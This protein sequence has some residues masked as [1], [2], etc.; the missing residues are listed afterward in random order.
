MGAILDLIGSYIFKAAMIGIIFATSYSL[1]E[2]MTKKAQM[3]NLEKSLNVQ[4]SVAEWDLRNIGYG[5]S[6]ANKFKSVTSTDLW[7]YGDIDN[8]G[9]MDSVRYQITTPYITIRDSLVRRYTITRRV[10]NGTP[11]N[12]MVKLRHLDVVYLDALG[13]VTTTPANIRAIRVKV[14]AESP[15]FI[16]DEMQ[17]ATRQITIFPP[18]LAL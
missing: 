11:Y 16:Q 12:V 15:V 1:N 5:Y 18:N 7:F 14:T 9:A 3:T 4:M 8:N 6:G 2:V 13:N 17:T 10:N